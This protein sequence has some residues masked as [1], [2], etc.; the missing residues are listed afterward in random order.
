MKN[1][2]KQT[3][4]RK[5]WAAILALSGFSLAFCAAGTEDAR[6]LGPTEQ[7]TKLADQKTTNTMMC[8]GLASMM[9]AIALLHRNSNQQKR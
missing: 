4:R 8:L 7:A 2:N 6:L 3:N 5:V 1:N 9:G